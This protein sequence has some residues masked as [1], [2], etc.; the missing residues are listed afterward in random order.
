MPSLQT[1]LS[2]QLTITSAILNRPLA[3]LRICGLLVILLTGFPFSAITLYAQKTYT[4]ST[5]PD[6]KQNGSGYVSDPAGVITPDEAASINALCRELEQSSTAQIAVVLLPSIGEDNPKEFATRLFRAWGI[7]QADVDNGLLILTV[8]DQRRTEF[9]TGDGLEGVLPDI[10]CYRIG[11]QEL[12]PF[13]KQDEYGKGLIAATRRFKQQLEQPENLEEIRSSG[14]EGYSP[15][16]GTPRPLGWYIVATLVFL[17]FLA[18]WLIYSNYSKQELYDRYLMVRKVYSWIFILLFPL[19]YLI[20]YFLLRRRLR[21]LRDQQRFSRKNGKPM[22]KLSESEDDRF[23]EAG[24]ITEE[25]IE[26]VDYDVWVTEE[27]DDV[28]ILRYDK[29]WSKYKSCPKCRYKAFHKAESRTLRQATYAHSGQREVIHQCKNCH[30]SKRQLFTIPKKTR[31]SSGGGFS[32]GGGSSWGGGSSSGGG[33]G[34]S[35]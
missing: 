31:S 35:W 8:L 21:Q 18:V 17:L 6:P 15:V 27:E 3:F 23:L 9:E 28:L 33:A 13:F 24:Q 22:R 19:P 1:S 11:M 7:G 29:R 14:R 26:A 10:L 34:V 30:Y 16:P 4:I 20:I 5:V 12:V 25:E 2:L 32:G